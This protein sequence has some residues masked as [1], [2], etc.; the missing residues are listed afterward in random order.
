MAR[1]DDNEL[2]DSFEEFYRSYYRNEIGELAQKYP[3]EEKS[4]Y[5]DWQDLY[6]FDPDLADDFRNKPTQ[7]LEYAEEA[8]RLYDLPVDV[9]LG[10]AHVRVHNLPQTTD[11]RAIRSDHRGMLIQIQGIVRKATDVRPKITTAAFECQRCGTLT[12]IPQDGDFQE[13]HECQGCERQGPFRINY[14]QSEFIDAQKLRV[15]ESPEGLRGGE[16]PQNIDVNIEDDITG[17][18]TAGDHVS[19]SGILKLEQQGGDREKSP[20]FDIYMDGMTVEIEDEQFEEMDIT[21]EDKKEIVELSNTPDIYEQME[22]AIAPSIYGFEMEKRAM[23]FQLFSG[24]TKFLPDES[25]TRGDLH[26]L[27]VGDPGTG[28]CM[29][30]DQLVTLADGRRKRIDDLVE[31]NLDDPKP[32]DDGVYDSVDIPVP[33]LTENGR[34]A[35]KRASKVWKREAPDE[36]YRLS[37][38]SGRTLEVTPSHPLFVQSGGDFKPRKAQDLREGSFVAA[39][40]MIPTTSTTALTVDYRRSRANNAVR[41][42]LP[43]TWEPWLARLIGYIIAEGYVELNEDNTGA[44]TITNEDSEILS[45]VKQSYEQLGLTYTERESR[46]SKEAKEIFCSAGEFVSFLQNLEPAVL[47]PSAEQR[48]P[49]AFLRADERTQ[50]AFLKAYIDSEGHVSTT[51]REITVAS[52]SRELLEGVRALLQSAGIHSTLSERQN[53]SYRLRISGDDFE[54]YLRE[55]GFVTERKAQAAAAFSEVSRNTNTDV[56]P[57]VDTLLREIRERLALSQSD[58][59]IP[60][61]TYQH[62][63]RGDRNPSKESLATVLSAFEKRLDYLRDLRVAVAEGDWNDIQRAREELGISQDSLAG[64]MDVTQTAVSYYERN[65]VVPD[66]GNVAGARDLIVERIDQALDASQQVSRLRK[67]AEA[68]IRWER[69]E[70]IERIEPEYD[71]VY[72]LEVKET[73]NYI[74]EGLVSHN[75][76]LLQYIRNIAPRSVYT[77]GKGSSSAGLCVT[78]DTLVHTSDGFREIREIVETKLPD[79]VEAETASEYRTELCTFDRESGTVEQREASHVWRMPQ[80]P[81][82]RIETRH[83][84]QLEASRRTP[85]LVCGEN[86][87]EWTDIADVTEGDHVAIPAYDVQEPLDR[88]CVPVREFLELTEEKVEL[89]DASLERVREALYEE[90][91]T[92]RDAA[93]ALDLSED[94]IYDHLSNQHVPLEKLDRILDATGLSR[95]DIAFERLMLRHGDSITI[96]ETFDADLLYLLGLVFGDGDIRLGRRDGNRG[97]V[98]ISNSDETILQNAIDIVAEKFDKEITIEYQEEK[99]PCIRIHS[100]TIARLFANAGME[101]PKDSL[102]LDPKLTTAAHADSF[103]R[104]L[105]DADGSVSQRDTGGSSVLLSTISDQ[106]AR[107]L[108]LMLETYGVRAIRR[109]RDRRGTS[110]RADG[111]VIESKHVQHFVEIYGE[112]IDR[113][114]EA[115]G[116]R[117]EE[118]AE[119]LA[120]LVGET[121]RRGAR[122]PIGGALATAEGPAGQFHN[123]LVGGANPGRDRAQAILESRELESVEPIV[124]ETVDASL[125]WDEVVT[126]TD[127]GP[128]EVF[129]LTVPGTHNF[130]G[131]GIVTHNTAAAVR[132]DFAEGQQWTLEAGALVLADQGIAAVDELDKM[133]CVTGDTLVHTPGGKKPIKEFATEWERSGSI[134]QLENGRTIRGVD[135]EVHTMTDAGTIERRAVTA[136]HEYRSPGT[137]YR[138]T[139]E[140]G[141]SVTTTADHPFIVHV[142]GKRATKPATAL[143]RGDYVYVPDAERHSVTD[144]GMTTTAD[145][146]SPNGGDHHDEVTSCRVVSV[147]AVSAENDTDASVYDLTVEGTHNFVANGMV[148]HNSEDQ[149]AMHEAL[150]QQSYHP[151]SEVLLADGR[152]VKIGEFVDGKMAAA[153]D[154]VVGGVDCEILPVED[155]GVHTVDL[156][157]NEIRKT[158]VD[159]VSRHEA[160][161]EFVRVEF[162]NGREVLVTPEHPLFVEDDGGVGTVEARAVEKGAFV[163]APRKLPNSTQPVS[164]DGEAQVGKEKDVDL[165]AELSPKLGEIL[166]FLI[167]EGH[168]YAGSSHEIG[169]SNQDE[170]LLD[171]MDR[172]MSSVFGMESSDTT[173]A[174]GTITKRWTSTK[175][176]RWFESN[177]PEVMHTAREKRIPAAVLGASEGVI[178]RFLVGA[179]AGDGGVE[180]EAMSFST[181]SEGLAEDYADALTKIGV[182]SRIHHDTAEDSWKT[183]VMGDSTEQFVEQVVDPA[184]PRHDDALEERTSLRYYRVTN[185]E[186]VPNEGEYACEWVYDITVEP[187]NTF[188]SQGVVLHNSISV[189]KAGINATLKSRCSLLGAANPTYGRFDEYEPIGEQIDLAPPLISRFDLIFTVT[190][191]PDEE[192]DAELAEHILQTNYA[193]ELNTHREETSTSNYSL[194]EVERVTEDVAPTI[195]PELLRKYVAYAKRNCYP[196]M[197]EEAKDEIQEY[198]VKLRTRGEAEDAPVPVTAR[199][200]EALVR[201]AEASARVRLSDTVEADDAQRAIDIAQYCL[202]DIGL[203]PETGELDADMIETGTSKSQRDRIMNIKSLIETIE[204]EYDEGAPVD[205]IVE[206]AEEQGMDASKAEHEIDK[207]KQ[208][209]EVYEPK[210]DHLRTT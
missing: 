210:T 140:S 196:T 191:Q 187:T 164:L 30:G 160:P 7:L 6:R 110:E 166:G 26:I 74:S 122:L 40:E 194:E 136:V 192:K 38:T 64:G 113:Y 163:P 143:D 156:E 100:A 27:L 13:P 12:R 80:K 45:D 190:D 37:T 66:G 5:V 135:A 94:F 61:T 105:M 199:K 81:C 22:G 51:Q 204:E 121:D 202:E 141:D 207:L 184:D 104:G 69:I 58:C 73:H 41:L 119:K 189:S 1:A 131:N 11:I 153:P 32:V 43:E 82:R 206:R 88:E 57:H 18:V 96:P 98:R 115:I 171:R 165:P 173:N 116:F 71:W 133:R 59:D 17:E 28:K 137:L 117:L 144:G 10:Q 16:T 157:S 129:D 139:L 72:D 76:Q 185:V 14:D 182:A 176:Y 201:L 78:G 35:E 25:R 95:E 8:L 84:K 19:V 103:L 89:A 172:L 75:S 203:D 169:F 193:G 91:G 159:R 205:V 197:T 85:V 114:A 126:A 53:D 123:N 3:N 132:D 200:L 70:T 148:I 47:E 87:I 147:E 50:A 102:A 155:V 195:D 120:A 106:L 107:Q 44:V 198:Y 174:A 162:S 180:S 101:T 67:V 167:A 97:C 150:E 62:Y 2:I 49:E 42:S 111:Y 152:R 175:L 138:V 54:T 93:A 36:M 168:S 29:K 77:S 9:S 33:S 99:V 46:P 60:R 170:R 149:S 39:P 128:K 48:V 145:S 4:L 56:V 83:G 186:T 90:F 179:F 127:T 15:Q 79:P 65:G 161:E 86:G 109:E 209:G 208:K 130:I 31:E 154:S 125:R 134:E 24:V 21:D 108:Q 151:N 181:A 158:D 142:D 34:I 68:P 20:M 183:Y 92:L 178:R 188:V 146:A 112:D 124:E 63:E 118:K 55:I 52:M 177:V 23:I